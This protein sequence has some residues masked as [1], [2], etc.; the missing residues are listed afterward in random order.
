MRLCDDRDRGA[1]LEIIN[2][3]ALA[4]R[5][6]IPADRWHEPYMSAAEFDAELAAGVLFHAE[7]ADGRLRGVMG[8]QDVGDVQLIRHA[9]VA[10]DAQGHGIGG[11]LLECLMRDRAG[12]VLVGTW[13]AAQWAIAFYLGHGFAQVS[14]QEKTRL[15]RRYWTV[16]ERQI[17]T[18]VVLRREVGRGL[19]SPDTGDVVVRNAQAGDSPAIFSLAQALATSFVPEQSAFARSL[20]MLLSDPQADVLVAH[21]A[22][23]PPIGYLLGFTHLTFFA[24]GPVS[25]IEELIVET[26]QRGRGVGR[27]LLGGF[28]ARAQTRGARL[29][30]LA[31]RRAAGFYTHFGYE[32]SAAYFR[33][34]LQTRAGV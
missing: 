8:I 17:E 27:M 29:V 21:H 7:E 31:T 25:W 33:R 22:D 19:P 16:P 11:A 10:P 6:V 32:E 30:A 15:L 9:Y 1:V 4:Y 34:T 2:T 13:G 23:E 24:N 18:S 20:E 14:D 3:A 12:P 26:S 28:E 5:G